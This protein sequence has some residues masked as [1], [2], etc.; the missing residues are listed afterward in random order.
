MKRIKIIIA[1]LTT[2]VAMSAYSQDVLQWYN[3][4]A[5]DSTGPDGVILPGTPNSP[6]VG[7]MVQLFRT[8]GSSTAPDWNFGPGD[9]EDTTGAGGSDSVI[10]FGYYG[11][12]DL[13]D[14]VFYA[15]SLFSNLGISSGTSIFVR[16]WDRPSSDGTGNLPTPQTYSDVS[17]LGL[18]GPTPGVVQ[19]AFYW[20]GTVQLANANPQGGGFFAY[21]IP[22]INE[23][24]WTFLPVPEPGTLALAGLGVLMLAFRRL[25]RTF[26]R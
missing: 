24:D 18:Y 22:T 20:E 16:V 9:F 23:G 7:A 25:R 26:V 8:G 4:G 17:L 10:N 6:S 3:P 11:Q 14:G 21:E 19:G 1:A 5:P 2:C 15:D 12:D 13:G